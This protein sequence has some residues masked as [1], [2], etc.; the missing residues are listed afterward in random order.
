M[1]A[2][3]QLLFITPE[4]PLL[5]LTLH[6]TADLSGIRIKPAN[7]GLALL[8]KEQARA[9][10]IRAKIHRPMNL[11]VARLLKWLCQMV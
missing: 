7:R 10:G 4:F 5:H 8:Y 6:G 2:N 9:F 3:I 1:L 11:I